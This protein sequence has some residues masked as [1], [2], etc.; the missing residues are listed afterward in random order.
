M[1]NVYSVFDYR[2]LAVGFAQPSNVYNTLP[3]ITLLPNLSNPPTGPGDSNA[4]NG[5]YPGNGSIGSDGGVSQIASGV[6]RYSFFLQDC[7]FFLST[8]YPT[9]HQGRN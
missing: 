9:F 1:K 2:S 3:N 7:F 4:T 8:G 6:S 5:S